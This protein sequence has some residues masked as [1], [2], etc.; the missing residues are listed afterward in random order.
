VSETD[1]T[2]EAYVDEIGVLKGKLHQFVHDDADETLQTE[3]GLVPTL[4]GIAKA[5]SERGGVPIYADITQGLAAT[6]PTQYFRTPSDNDD[7]LDILYQHRVGDPDPEAKEV[8]RSPSRSV[9]R[10][11]LRQSAS[12]PLH[13]ILTFPQPESLTQWAPGSAVVVPAEG[14]FSDGAAGLEFFGPQAST[15]VLMDAGYRIDGS[16]GTEV[17]LDV[18]VDAMSG[19]SVAVGIGVSQSGSDNAVHV[20][21]RG[22]GNLFSVD[23]TGNTQS[24]TSPDPDL[25]YQAG[26]RVKVRLSFRGDGQ[27]PTVSIAKNGGG[28]TAEAATPLPASGDLKLAVRHEVDGVARMIVSPTPGAEALGSAV[29]D[30][31]RLSTQVAVIGWQ[32]PSALEFLPAMQASAP[33]VVVLGAGPYLADQFRKLKAE[34]LGLG[35]S[36]AGAVDIGASLSMSSVLRVQARLEST[37]YDP[38]IGLAYGNSIEGLT[39]F[40]VRSNNQTL[41]IELP[42]GTT[43]G[44]SGPAAEPFSV[45]DTVAISARL[46][47]AGADSYAIQHV[48]EYADGTTAGPYEVEVDN[49][50]SVWLLG[51]S[52]AVW[53]DVVVTTH[54][55]PLYISEL[56]GQAPAAGSRIVYVAPDGDDSSAGTRLSPLATFGAAYQQLGPTGGTIEVAGGEYRENVSFPGITGHLSIRAEPYKRAII[57]GSEELSLSKTDGYT[58]IYEA[59]LAEKPVGMGGSRGPAMIFEMGTPSKS[60]PDAERHD[61]QRGASHR[62]PYTEMLE[63]ASLADLDTAG[64][65]G[66]WYWESGVLYLAATDGSDASLKRYEARTRS[67]LSATGS[68]IE[69]ERIDAFFSANKG[70]N[71]AGMGRVVRRECRVFG[72]Y[73]DGFTDDAMNTVSYRDESAGNGNDGF[74]GHAQPGYLLEGN[75]DATYEAVY[76]DPW[77]HDNYDDGRSF[78]ERGSCSVYGG[79]FEHNNKAGCVDVMGAQVSYYNTISRGADNGFY[80]ATDPDEADSRAGTVVRCHNCFSEGNTYNYRSASPTALLIAQDSRSRDAGSYHY[81]STSDGALRAEN[82]SYS[83]AGTATLGTVDVVVDQPLAPA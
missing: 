12:S 2:Y 25:A 23:E 56:L 30:E 32:E 18:Q 68:S 21:Y 43:T 61:L 19:D 69:L 77:G 60:V 45:G 82:C 63:A 40:A 16:R 66:M 57:L 26:D 74:N 75:R 27:A 36:N 49:I 70:M 35:A 51:R 73:S 5:V 11:S 6:S 29:F 3:G 48:I 65:L 47:S 1:N 58:Q 76:F 9:V 13:T 15:Y 79:L 37:I 24:I 46:I 80:A 22:S 38:S 50:D 62:L 78:H 41:N 8:G 28:Y 4:A 31:T 10:K 81:A 59:Q 39:G 55:L 64:G 83:G 72:S 34:F 7:E 33:D 17:V 67:T 52:D 42:G 44:A 53:A 14:A 20:V 54:A 71:F